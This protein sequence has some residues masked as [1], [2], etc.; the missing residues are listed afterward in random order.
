MLSMPPATITS[1]EPASSMSCANIAARMP[2]P[3]ILLTVVLPVESGSLAPSAAC[4]AGA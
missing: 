3:H 1:T 4:R 2:E